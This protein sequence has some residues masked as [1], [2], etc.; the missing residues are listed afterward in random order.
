[1]W[2]FIIVTVAFISSAIAQDSV[3]LRFDKIEVQSLAKA[4]FSEI[5]KRP[6]V[7]DDEV[8]KKTVS[9]NI[10]AV[11][12]PMVAFTL[13]AV[14]ETSGVDVKERQGIVFIG[15]RRDDEL[16]VHRLH[17]R[18]SAAVLDLLRSAFPSVQAQVQKSQQGSSSAVPSLV[19]SQSA[20]QSGSSSPGGFAAALQSEVQGAKAATAE[21]QSGF[22][23]DDAEWLVFRVASK[24]ARAARELI[25]LID[26]PVDNLQVRAVAY[27][28]TVTTDAGSA[29]ELT[30]NILG[31][32]LGINLGG[33]SI[34][35]ANALTIK[36]ANIEAVLKVLDSDGRYRSVSR[37]V[38]RVRSG[39][40]GRFSVGEEVPTLGGVTTNVGGATQSVVYKQA[41]T[42]F[43]V[44]PV[45]KEGGIDLRIQQTVSGFRQTSTSQLNSPTLNKRE[46]QTDLTVQPGEL[47]VIAGLD[48]DEDSDAGRSFF[49]FSLG[50]SRTVSKR[51]TILLLE[52][53]KS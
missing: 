11:D 25:Q 5:L 43:E 2:R 16:I 30:A 12:K 14:L 27:D 9:I 48:A 22:R 36:T 19:S 28:V 51:Q 34:S 33:P 41:G 23:A 10:Q 45:V 40:K 26:T 15:A 31:G 4:V 3:S 24:D 53:N 21:T 42:I 8:G 29:F 20:V 47:I 32:K 38:V 52:V 44:Q 6:Y 50:S 35:R 46:L 1:M 18:Q 17:H 49:G 37:P 13:A 7:V 39:G